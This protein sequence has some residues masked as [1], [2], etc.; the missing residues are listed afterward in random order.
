MG[1]LLSLFLDKDMAVVDQLL[2]ASR[3]SDSP[4]IP[5]KR[6]SF[7]SSS[8]P[9]PTTKS[10]D[11]QNKTAA[12][13]EMH[14]EHPD[15]ESPM[16]AKFI[17]TMSRIPQMGVRAKI[18][19]K[20]GR[21]APTS[22]SHGAGQP[23]GSKSVKAI[24]TTEDVSICLNR[25]TKNVRDL[26]LEKDV[27]PFQGL[28]RPM[29]FHLSKVMKKVYGSTGKPVPALSSAST[30]ELVSAEIER[31]RECLEL[32]SSLSYVATILDLSLRNRFPNDAALCRELT[33]LIL[34]VLSFMVLESKD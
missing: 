28:V 31:N 14:D 30:H 26:F 25:Y 29:S 33:A 20:V 12:G 9:R 23:G 24:L 5:F 8:P 7:S 1:R 16:R 34:E 2:E 13:V 4:P 10:L 3:D 21:L 18:G 17:Q 6:G 11:N 19:Q 15:D 22:S 32:S 27:K